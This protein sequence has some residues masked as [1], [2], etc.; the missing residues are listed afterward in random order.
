MA[1]ATYSAPPPAAATIPHTRRL[2]AL[3]RAL[4]AL[5]STP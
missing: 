1:R 3:L 5:R 2:L 4:R